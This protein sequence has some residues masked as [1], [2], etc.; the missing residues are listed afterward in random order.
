VLFQL[1][2]WVR[3][4]HARL[5]QLAA[6]PER[7]PGHTIAVECRDRSWFPDHAEETLGVLRA[8]GLADVVVDGP[9]AGGAVPRVPARTAPTVVYRLHGRNTEGWLRQ[10]RGEEP[11]VREK[12]DYLYDDAE[13]GALVPE[14]EG[15]A[16]EASASSSRSTTTTARIRSRT[17]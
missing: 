14:V 15:V 2:P 17:P 3:Y 10:L 7:L 12:Y 9:V 1:A 5:D 11:T 6:L 16:D 13:L 4:G 8:A